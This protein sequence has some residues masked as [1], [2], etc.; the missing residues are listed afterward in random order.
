MKLIAKKQKNDKDFYNEILYVSSKYDGIA[1]NPN[2]KVHKITQLFAFYVPFGILMLGLILLLYIKT[3]NIVALVV[4]VQ[5]IIFL[6][7]PL[8]YL[9]YSINYM[10]KQLKGIEPTITINKSGIRITKAKELD[11]LLSWEDVFYVII[12]NNSVVFLPKD[13]TKLIIGV[14]SHYKEELVK[15]V[16]DEG[17]EL[18]LIDNSDLYR[19]KN[20]KK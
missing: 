10:R 2:M 13:K 11:Y 6:L 19:G 20:E 15:A 17:K 7:M 5:M 18:L 16:K 4:V 9:F 8:Y 3:K 12:E 14:N 1:K